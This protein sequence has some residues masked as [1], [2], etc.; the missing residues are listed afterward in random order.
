MSTIVYIRWYNHSRCHYGCNFTHTSMIGNQRYDLTVL[1]NI[2]TLTG[3]KHVKYI[4][5]TCLLVLYNIWCLKYEVLYIAF[6]YLRRYFSCSLSHW[7]IHV[8]QHVLMLLQ[9]CKYTSRNLWSIG[10]KLKKKK[11]KC[12]CVIKKVGPPI[13]VLFNYQNE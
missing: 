8:W 9:Q 6:K 10:Q 2:R 7:Y 11:K 5:R 1:S 3:L 12:F 4:S 13:Y